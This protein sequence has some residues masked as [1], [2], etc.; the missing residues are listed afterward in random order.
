[1]KKTARRSTVYFQPHLHKAL[2]LKSA[3]TQRS[4]RPRASPVTKSITLL[5]SALASSIFASIRGLLAQCIL[6][7]TH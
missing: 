4:S 5:N 7:Q 1:M 3:T 2:R 6:V